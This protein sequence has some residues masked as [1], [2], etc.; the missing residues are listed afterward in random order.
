MHRIGFSVNPI[1][2]MGGRVGLKGTDGIANEAQAAGA[3]PT[4]GPRAELFA[5]TFLDLSKHDENLRVRWLTCGGA[6]GVASSQ[7][8]LS[9]AGED[10]D[11]RRSKRDGAE[12][13]GVTAI[14]YSAYEEMVEAEFGQLV[15]HAAERWPDARIAVRHRLGTIPTGEA[16]IGIAA[17]APHRAEAFDACRFVIEEVKRRIP[18]WKK[19]LR[20]DGTEVWVDPSGRPTSK[21]SHV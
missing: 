7:Q 12:E 19:E 18:V 8:A 10:A 14:E 15:A 9:R 6:M 1:A 16:S 11:Q 5:R 2:G 17:A 4:A 21:P 20:L 13:D 3:E